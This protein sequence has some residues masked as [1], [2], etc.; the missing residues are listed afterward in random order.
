MI[1]LG[2]DCYIM[3]K[4]NI[5]GKILSLSRLE[6]KKIEKFLNFTKDF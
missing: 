6:N 2:N 5:E 1:N 3:I 4:S